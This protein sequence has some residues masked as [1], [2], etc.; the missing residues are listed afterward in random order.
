MRR[1]S[2][3]GFLLLLIGILYFLAKLNVIHFGAIWL[4]GGVIWP[5]ITALIGVYFAFEAKSIRNAVWPLYLFVLGV[6]LMVKDA[7]VSPVLSSIGSGWNLVWPLLLVFAGLDLVLPKRGGGFF[8]RVHMGDRSTDDGDGNSKNPFDSRGNRYQRTWSRSFRGPRRRSWQNSK[9]YGRPPADY[10]ARRWIGEL[11]VGRS[12][13]TLR[14][15]EYWTGLGET[16]INLAT[17]Y[18]ED[19]DYVLDVSGWLGEIR[20]LVPES[21]DVAVSATVGVGSIHL[22]ADKE[23]SH[24]G[25]GGKVVHEDPGYAQSSRRCRLNVN[26][27]LGEVAIVRV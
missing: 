10:G 19:G 18:I 17:A 23:N 12:P 8:V 25:L 13:W 4:S 16:R 7:H 21:L 11:M 3:W 14:S 6:L 9:E 5:G 2:R 22:F 24:D 15:A 20:I 27:H 1:G 26:L